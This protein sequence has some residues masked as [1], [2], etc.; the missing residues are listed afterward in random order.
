MSSFSTHMS[1]KILDSDSFSIACNA[2]FNAYVLKAIDEE[3][4]LDINTIRRLTSCVQYFYKSDTIPHV[5][6]GANILSMLLN[7]YGGEV[8]ELIKIAE[9]VF[10]QVGDFPNLNLLHKSYAKPIFAD[11]IVDQIRRDIR[12]E[13]NTIDQIEFPLTD[14][15]RTLWDDLVSDN[16]VITS[17][18]TSAGKTY[19]ILHYLI[20]E[21]ARSES[22]FVAIVVPTRALISEVARKIYEISKFKTIEESIEICTVPKDGPF[23]AKTFFVMT[24]ERL[25]EVLQAGDLTFNYLFIDEAHNISDNSRGVLLH[26]T[27]QRLLDGSNPQI[28]TSMPSQRYENAFDSVFGD[29]EFIKR[30]TSHSPVSKIVINVKLQGRDIHL[31]RLGGHGYTLIKK[32]FKGNKLGNIVVRMGQGESNLI[33]RNQT[34]HC[35]ATANDIASLI[36]EQLNN[37][38]LE[39]AANYVERFLH[40]DF[41]LA[42]NLRKGIAFHYGPL[43]GTIRSMIEDLARDEQINF[44]VCTSTLAE[45]VNLPAKNL[46]L[47]NP[48]Q[49]TARGKSA[50]RMEDVKLNNITGRAGR[51]L[52]HFSGNIF[53]INHDDWAFKDYFDE[54]EE[55]ID[56]VP[57]YFKVLNEEFDSIIAVLRGAYD[58]DAESQYLFYT[59]ANKLIKEYGSNSLSKTMESVDLRLNNN[60]KDNLANSIRQAYE[61]LIVDPFTLEANPS[62]GFIQQNRLYN[63]IFEQDHLANWMLPH[64]RSPQLYDRLLS[65]SQILVDTGIFLPKEKYTLE[66]L[67]LVAKKW[68]TGEPIKSIINGQISSDADYYENYNCNRSV[69]NVIKIINDEIRFRMSS[70][71]RCYHS[72]ITA[73][74]SSRKVDLQSVKLYTYIEIGGC[75][76]RT[77]DLI[78]L[79]LSRE[80]ALEV[81]SVLPAGIEVTTLSSLRNLDTTGRFN[82]LHPI[83]QREITTRAR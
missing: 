16:D 54:P 76:E 72:L 68:I 78:N 27:I 24:Q 23:K 28:I 1:A 83:T 47:T 56:K 67:C 51:M 61:N 38:H 2:M 13:L 22:A 7:L 70:A 52:G 36:D 6:E 37:P 50:A 71:L 3:Y 32:N 44:I 46:F 81:N 34:N 35:E 64:P 77:V 73:I 21:I 33:Y 45:G 40:E 11:A 48:T 10:F 30:S 62:I 12:S 42:D 79:G 60:Q 41:S 69:R 75:D 66:Y 9:N 55:E 74:I 26:L 20:D 25:F 15:Q 14:Y 82:A 39:E 29:I 43:P 59:I 31:S 80:T 17:A 8:P 53:L 18:P 4:E 65:I 57:T 63:F 58:H 5:R 19:I 49:A